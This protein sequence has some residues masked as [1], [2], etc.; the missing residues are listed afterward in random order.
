MIIR[1]KRYAFA[2][3]VALMVGAS[4]MSGAWLGFYPAPADAQG[5]ITTAPSIT[6]TPSITSSMISSLPSVH[7][8]LPD[9]YSTFASVSPKIDGLVSTGEWDLAAVFSLEHGFLFCQNDAA[10]LYLL[11]DLTADTQ[12]DSG[13]YFWLS[14]DV[15]TDQAITPDVDLLYSTYPGTWNLGMCRYAG[16][17]ATSGLVSTHSQLGAGFGPSARS[18]ASHR[19]FEL[20]ISLS[21][22]KSAPNGLTRIG[23]RTHSPSPAFTDDQPEGYDFSRFLRVILATARVDL[24]ILTHEDFRDSLRPLMEHKNYTG[25]NTIISSWQNLD[26]GFGSQGRDEAE[27]V[28]RGIAAY[29]R[30]CG[31]RY[32]MLVGDCDRFPVRYT[33]TDRGTQ[34]AYNRAF[35]SAD[36][37]YADLY[38]SNGNF[39]T[40]DNN[41]NGYYGEIH[42]ETI[43]GTLNVDRVDLNPDLAV[44]RVPAS[45]AAEV[46][47]Y[48][49]K[50]ISYEFSAYKS[51][52]FKKALLLASTDWISDACQTQED[53]ASNYLTGF[54][55]TRLYSA[56]N[57]CVAT[58]TLNAVNINSALN[59]GAGFVSYLGHGYGTG[60][61]GCYDASNMASLANTDK[62][63]IIIAGA[64]D[65]AQFTTQ[66][67]YS[68]YTDLSGTHHKGTNSGEVFTNVPAQPACIQTADN[69]ESLSEHF[70]VRRS[71]GAVG[72]IGCVTGAQPFCRDL[73]RYFFEGY[74]YQ[75][76]TL[77]DMW[78]YMVRR[79]YQTHVP[80]AT[81]NPADWTRVADF[82]QPWKFHLFGDPSLR[83]GGV[84]RIQKQDFLGTYDMIHDGWRGTL[85]L[86][87]TN[88]DTIENTPNVEGSYTASDGKVHNV[89]GYVRTW[90]YSLSEGWGPDHKICFYVDFSDTPQQDD[91]QKFDGCLFT[92]TKDAIAGVTWWQDK[93][94]GF[95]ALKSALS[96][97]TTP[98]IA[99]PVSLPLIPSSSGL[100]AEPLINSSPS[101]RRGT[102]GEPKAAPSGYL[103]TAYFPAQPDAVQA[104]E[105]VI[106]EERLSSQTS[107]TRLISEIRLPD[108]TTDVWLSDAPDVRMPDITDVK[109]LDVSGVRISDVTGVG[110]SN[111]ADSQSASLARSDFLGTY[112]MVHDGWKGTLR[113]RGG[114]EDMNLPNLE[115]TYTGQDGKGHTVYGYVRTMAC[116]LPQSWGP[117]HKILFYI[118][119]SDTANQHN[120]DQKFE[121]YLFT[122]TKDAI[123]GTTWWQGIPF[124]FYAVKSAA[125]QAPLQFIRPSDRIFE[126]TGPQGIAM[127]QE[128]RAEFL[129]EA[130]VFDAQGNKIRV[131]SDAP[132]VFP[133]GQTVVTFWVEDETE[134]KVVGTATVTVSDTTPPVIHI[135]A[136]FTIET[137]NAEGVPVSNTEIQNFLYEATAMDA[138]DGSITVVHDAPDFFE[139]GN[140]LITFRAT[141]R[142]GNSASAETTIT[143]KL[144]EGSGCGS[145]DFN[146]DGKVTPLDALSVF[147]CYLS[148]CHTCA[149][150]N[151]DGK[152]TPMDALCLFNTYLGQPSC[153]D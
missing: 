58:S 12:K 120:D 61:A 131:F 81:V 82:H 55:L 111:Q 98:A 122:W 105:R 133:V 46:T 147:K 24:L 108:I 152:V 150:I 103:E 143:V 132:S 144:V 115:G 139:P 86:W 3:W 31:T 134:N 7:I 140:I 141:D 17:G 8:L 99:Y 129:A 121:G 39:D 79:Y 42:G 25:I 123:A 80:P 34:E 149:D 113:L 43:T 53:I 72:Y 27:R 30:L 107:E 94:F 87:A 4:V 54:S 92:W 62:L 93:P 142:S 22:I 56:G 9:I 28:K 60:W 109:T 101:R 26:H 148:P 45:T 97:I 66:P 89:Y 130:Q 70:L 88:G 51:D 50:I 78:N 112:N 146:G 100:L 91:D 153:L 18:E 47:T 37:Y 67:P 6:S 145:G 118:D 135:P 10:N 21:E 110:I 23:L 38:R 96:L 126:Q 41:N 95:Y 63:P 102:G 68:P 119:F 136:P 76:K 104:L 36:L 29:E 75:C 73:N 65:T 59:Q 128:E 33:M 48:V 16:A 64:C 71:T 13:D 124:G 44:G 40:W 106:S 5:L 69:P 1:V 137:K 90:T 2:V 11:L 116:P 15:D 114:V 35:Y 77:G 127:S 74:A 83:I 57:P 85:T 52:W 20:A 32:V 19:I 14:F 138:V 84:S 117:D 151:G 49:N 125:T